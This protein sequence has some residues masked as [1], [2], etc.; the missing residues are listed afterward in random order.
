MSWRRKIRTE[1]SIILI[2][3]FLFNIVRNIKFIT[4]FIFCLPLITYV[5][6]ILVRKFK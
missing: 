4:V 6:F 2:Y 5:S 1:I 3:I